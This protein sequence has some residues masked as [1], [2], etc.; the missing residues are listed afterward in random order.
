MEYQIVGRCLQCQLVQRPFLGSDPGCPP[1]CSCWSSPS[2]A[3]TGSSSKAFSLFTA[4]AFYSVSTVRYT[5]RNADK[6]VN[7]VQTTG[8]R[9]LW[10]TNRGSLWTTNRGKPLWTTNRGSLWTTNRGKPLWTTNRGSLWTTNRGR[11]LWTTNRGSL[12]TTNRGRPLWTTNR[13][14]PVRSSTA[15]A[16]APESEWLRVKYQ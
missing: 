3:T 2:M 12:W 11:P 16:T 7:G 6:G 9:P 13:G 4:A 1:A 15:T 8:R 10:T 5:F 14:R